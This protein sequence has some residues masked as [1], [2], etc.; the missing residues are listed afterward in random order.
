M[1]ANLI[2][3]SSA[4][5]SNSFIDIAKNDRWNPS[6]M[7]YALLKRPHNTLILSRISIFLA[8]LAQLGKSRGVDRLTDEGC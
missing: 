1:K 7:S 3:S 6:G 4:D 2:D 8:S 5:E